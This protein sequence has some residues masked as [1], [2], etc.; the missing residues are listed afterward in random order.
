MRVLA[1]AAYWFPDY[2]GGTERVV[3]TTAEALAARGHEVTVIASRVPGEPVF[4]SVGG[5]KVRRM[6]RRSFLPVTI[7]DVLE[8]RRAIR[9]VDP[10]EFDVILA[11]DTV[12]AL[13][14]MLAAPQKPLAF[15][16]HASGFLESKQRRSRG[17]PPIEWLRAL[18][19]EPVL[20]HF[21]RLAVRRSPRILVLSEFSR[22]IVRTVD[23]S[24]DSRVEVVGGGVDIEAFTPA[25][26]R[27]A[28]RAA[29]GIA[30]GEVVLITARRLVSRMGVETLLD[31]FSQ[32]RAHRNDLRLFV[33]GIG[34]MRGQL[35]RQR[36]RLGLNGAVSFLGKVPDADLL[37]WY[38]VADLFVLPTIAYEGFGMVTAE[39]LACG[40]PVVATPVG[41]SGEILEPLDPS[42]IA[43][44]ASVDSL[45]DAI[46][47]TLGRID[48]GF[49]ADCRNYAERNLAW[50]TVIARWE[51]ALESVCAD[52][53]S[54]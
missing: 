12:F 13:A 22:Q 18:A 16:F 1:A 29:A 53:I 31:A 37:N 42:L 39:A 43:E 46:E 5:V 6:M 11:H 23:S 26:D 47:V 25:D 20:Y 4:S 32:L 33:I 17:L 7:T 21:E 27:A 51:S 38:R 45:A 10:D 44:T 36:D 48:D 34:E 49:R 52:A 19:L 2:A 8:M 50:D 54:T 24:A 3:R 40:T 15:V 35:E 28:L 30:S 41:A 9:A 14:A